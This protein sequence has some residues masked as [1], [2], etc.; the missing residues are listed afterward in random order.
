MTSPFLPSTAHRDRSFILGRCGR[1]DGAPSPSRS[2]SRV[3]TSQSERQAAS[4]SHHH[5]HAAK[6]AK[7]LMSMAERLGA[8][9]LHPA[10]TCRHSEPRI[11]GPWLPSLQLTCNTASTPREAGQEEQG[12]PTSTKP[13]RVFRRFCPE[14]E[15]IHK[16]SEAVSKGT[17]EIVW[18]SSRLKAVL[19]TNSLS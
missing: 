7:L 6:E 12:L 10:P 16:S 15:A 13:R 17:V 8:P 18:E 14:E 2:Q 19:K 4:I 9:F 11:L 1:E 5:P 3:T